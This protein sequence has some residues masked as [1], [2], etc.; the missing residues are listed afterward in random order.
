M[1]L[2][3]IRVYP[4]P[5][6]KEKIPESDVIDKELLK[7][8]KI[9]PEIMYDNNG[10]GLA[11]PQIGIKER[12]IILDVGDGLLFMINPVIVE[13][14]SEE[15][16]DEEGCLSVPGTYLNIV[17]HKSVTVE[18]FDEKLKKRSAKLK[19]LGARAVQHEIDHLNGTIILDKVDRKTRL[20]AEMEY[21]DYIK[22]RY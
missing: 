1:S 19:D 8:F 13:K 14:S 6:L 4:D 11:A 12:I 21:M 20:K 2:L 17:R 18:Y 7:Y 15:E 5:I 22:K 3:N 10:A 9:M 16:T